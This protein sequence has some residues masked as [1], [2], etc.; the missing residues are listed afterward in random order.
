MRGALRVCLSDLGVSFLAMRTIVLVILLASCGGQVTCGGAR[1][2]EQIA[3]VA[4]ATV[5]FMDP[6]T[7]CENIV[8][9]S[10]AEADKTNDLVSYTR[11]ESP[12]GDKG[13]CRFHVRATE[14]DP[15][16]MCTP[17]GGKPEAKP[18][19]QSQPQPQS[20]LSVP[21]DAATKPAAKP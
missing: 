9:L 21:A 20:A 8:E 19:A 18:V 1:P 7:K 2:E 12:T 5:R 4:T 16:F 17:I 3:N 13:I 15:V 10:I 11:C 6:K 14:H